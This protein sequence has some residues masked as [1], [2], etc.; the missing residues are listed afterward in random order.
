M[1]QLFANNAQSTLASSVNSSVTTLPLAAGTGALFPSPTGG[2]FFMLTLT[3]PGIE[4]S[5]EIVKVTAR[6][7]DS[8]TVVRAQEG[9]SAASWASGSKAE[10][11]LTAGAKWSLGNIDESIA[12]TWTGA[13]RFDQ[14]VGIGAS[15]SNSTGSM[16]VVAGAQFNSL[17]VRSTGSSGGVGSSDLY[18]GSASGDLSG[19][20]VGYDHGTNTLGLG[21]GGAVKM[22]INSAG[23]VRVGGSFGTTGQV[24]TS[25]GSSS[26]AVWGNLPTAANPTA[27]VGLT[28]MSGSGS[29]FMRSDAA[30]ALDQGISPTWTGNHTFSNTVTG[31]SFTPTSSTA[32][33]NGMCLNGTNTLALVTNG[34]IGLQINSTGGVGIGTA[35]SGGRTL[36]VAAA[37]SSARFTSSTGTNSVF[38]EFS[39]SGGQSFFGRDDSTGSIFGAGAYGTFLW[40]SGSTALTFF[41][42][43]VAR[44]EVSATGNLRLLADGKEL[45]IGAGNDL[46][47]YHDGTDSYIENDTGN[48]VLKVGGE[49]SLLEVGTTTTA[50]S[51]GGAGALPATPAEYVTV[52][53]NGATRKVAVY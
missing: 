39:N 41:T 38:L 8:L 46:R 12:P 42:N 35:A 17:L 25:A 48:L 49:L 11:R 45:Q 31:A 27:S 19:G 4:A 30:P 33:T 26:P 37:T 5:W 20:I 43:T 10:L 51:A 16:L 14:A 2:D 52:I 23:A 13:H 34:S 50:P 22:S 28:A 15:N 3:Q 47:L 32:P 29:T 36:D 24:M 6:S 9:T 44:F 1:T 7:T 53:I 18:L 21:A 40:S